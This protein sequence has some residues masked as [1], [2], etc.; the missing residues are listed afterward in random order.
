MASKVKTKPAVVV[1]FG[2]SGDLTMRKLMPALYNLYL[3]GW[4]PEHFE[5][6]GTGR[7]AM[8][9]DAFR[10]AMQEGVDRFSRSGKAKAEKW[11]AFAPHLSYVSGEYADAATHARLAERV[12]RFREDV[13]GEATALFYLATPPDIV[14]SIAKGLSQAGFTQDP[15][16][17]RIVVEKP[18]GRDL[19]SARALNRKLLEDFEERQ[20][21]RIDHYLGKETVQNILA[22]RF[23]NS[24]IEPVWN[25]RYVD[26]VQITVG[27]QVGVEQ[28]SGYYDQSGALRDML[29]N[30]LLQ[31]MCLTAMECPTSFDPEEV[32]DKKG[33]VLK[34]IRP[35][36]A[37][38]V[39]DFA[40]RGQ[41]GKGEYDC[42]G[43]PA[44]RDEPGVARDSNTETFAALKLH[45]DNW[46]WDGVHFYI[47][48]GKRLPARVSE[49][50]VQF[51]PVPHLFFPPEAVADI[52]PNRMV[53]RV[54][55]DQGISLRIEAKQ[56][57][58]SMRLRPVDMKFTY[59][60]A[61]DAPEPEA[62]ETLL[63]D[64]IRG[65]A[66]LFMRA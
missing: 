55:P 42:K 46:R 4:L 29:Q 59:A 40:V 26:H 37:D 5:I 51:R 56:P 17:D 39:Q 23:G 58:P 45:V 41:Y 22:L 25:R 27:E 35:I 63:F 49:V 20:I 43:V 9:D 28:R 24:L 11:K 54:Q 7:K 18:F 34:A 2:A 64:A 31:V 52:I 57:G 21:F 10:K 13:D 61:F 33:D 12:K 48:T 62:Y 50:V 47:R 16:R 8:D 19:E 44:Y 38:R 65:D 6:I 66:T 1:I 3:D 32:R 30:H 15:E 60:E 53:I 36:P 14:E